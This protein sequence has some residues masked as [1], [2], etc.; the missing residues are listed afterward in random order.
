MKELCRNAGVALVLEPPISKTCLF[1]SA[2]WFDV[3]RAIIQMSL[4]MKTND[5]FWWTFFHEAAHISLHRGRNFADDN[6][7]EGD[8]AEEEADRWAE[9]VLVGRERFA[10]FKASRPRSEVSV[11]QFAAEA[12]LHPGIVVGMLQHAGVISYSHL[13]KLKV[14]FDW[15]N[16]NKRN[17]PAT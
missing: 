9:H 7:G 5:H 3:D 12:N 17:P 10:R 11:R 2:R 13:N 14:T 16:H 1:G 15:A 6:N 8:G 4:R